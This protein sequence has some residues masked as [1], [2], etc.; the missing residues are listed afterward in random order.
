MRGLGTILFLLIVQLLQAQVVSMFIWDS[1][2]VT[3][4]SIGP[5][6]TSVGA[7]AVSSA[8]GVGGTNGLNPGPPTA[9][10]INLT[11]TNTGNVFDLNN[12]D[13][14]IDYRRNESTASMVKRTNFN[15]NNGNSIA[16][17][18]VVYRVVSGAGFATITSTAYPI[19][20][21][22]VFRTYRFTY[23]NCTGVGT[24]YVNN[25]VVWTSPSPTVNTNLYWVGE[26]SL[27]I[28]QDMDGANNNIPNLDNF[29]L[30]PFS[31]SPLPIELAAFEGNAQGN[32]NEF[33][34]ITFSEKNND[35]FTLER[36][37]DGLLWEEVG[38]VEGAGTVSSKR[39]YK[40]VETHP[41]PTI[42][43]YRL[44]QTDYDGKSERFNIIS[45]DNSSLNTVKLMRVTDV[46]GR[47]LNSDAVGLRFEFYS[48]G[49]VVRRAE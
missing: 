23:N 13:V 21:D 25:T 6:A 47:E 41:K 11:V 31:C 2:P 42:N 36:S 45:I 30:Q 17:F 18:Q 28:G 48:D 43:Y 12:I 34:W 10:N 27:I 37:D 33:S 32:Y 44:L 19:P 16:N 35:Y 26:G 9:A 40:F 46:L 20:L 14:K 5:N 38:R 7:S 15:F 8:G 39:S 49:T 24:M 4:A 3:T 1:G 29:V 22:N